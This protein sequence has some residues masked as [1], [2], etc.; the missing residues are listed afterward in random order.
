MGLKE[1]ISFTTLWLNRLSMLLGFFISIGYAY[2]GFPSTFGL[3][4]GIASSLANLY[5]M[6]VSSDNA[7]NKNINE[8]KNY[9]LKLAYV[10][11][12]TVAVLLS[13]ASVYI[14]TQLSVFMLAPYLTAILS[15]SFLFIN[16]HVL[17]SFFTLSIFLFSVIQL[18]KRW[19]Q[20]KG[21]SPDAIKINTYFQSFTLHFSN[22][23][24]LLSTLITIGHILTT[25]VSVLNIIL[26]VFLSLCDLCVLCIFNYQL[27]S[28]P[29]TGKKTTAQ[30]K[31][32]GSYC[33]ARSFLIGSIISILGSK[34]GSFIVHFTGT[35]I[36]G[37]ALSL[38]FWLSLSTAIL[39][40]TVA[41]IS[42]LLFSSVQ[43]Y[44][45]WKKMTPQAIAME[46]KRTNTLRKLSPS[47]CQLNKHTNLY[48]DH[49]V[50]VPV[51]YSMFFKNVRPA[52][53]V[54]GVSKKI[55]LKRGML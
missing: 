17:A 45:L 24:N 33:K 29:T 13:S 43:A 39:I 53:L 38:P 12:A 19:K 21:V 52:K 25:S 35:L 20:L 30:I 6:W 50:K 22:F 2:V 1:K 36:L 14:H 54:N 18:Y 47:S 23:V 44:E 32:A 27:L 5:V 42:G 9:Y 31:K 10:A 55:K 40:A 11:I 15:T 7:L 46:K 48:Y 4:F 8:S 26:S 3:V 28:L 41:T 51:K 34:A 16:S 49:G 37:A